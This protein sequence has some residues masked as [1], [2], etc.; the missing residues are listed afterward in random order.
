MTASAHDIAAALR[1]RLP[2]LGIMKLH[3]LLFYCQGLHLAW[4]GKPLFSEYI[5]AFDHGPLVKTFWQEER[6][7]EPRPE[8]HELGETE[9]NTIGYVASRYGRLNVVDLVRLT[10]AQ[11]PWITADQVRRLGG[12]DVIEHDWMRTFFRAEI[13]K[14]YEEA[15]VPREVIQAWLAS[16]PRP[17]GPGKPDDID[18][19]L[20]KLHA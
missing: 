16:V 19:L 4:F 2:G 3:K 5:R 20:A 15:G 9:L 18:A 12:S 8:P 13:D 10:H 1:D 17:T 6:D 11:D 7:Q 14:E